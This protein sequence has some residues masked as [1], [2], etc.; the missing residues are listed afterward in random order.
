MSDPLTSNTPRDIKELFIDIPGNPTTIA[1][2]MSGGVDSSV[3][4]ALMAEQGKAQG[5]QVIGVTMKLWDAGKSGELND[6]TCCTLDSSMDARKVCDQLGIPHYTLDMTE[7]F[8]RLV[9]EPF[10]QAYLKAQTPNPCVNCNSFVKWDALWSKVKS[11]GVSHLA[12]GHYAETDH[13]D[14]RIYIYRGEDRSKDQSYFLW[15][16]PPENLQST[17]FPITGMTKPEVREIARQYELQT[18]NKSESMDICFIPDG[19]KNAFL[20]NRAKERG[21]KFEGGAIVS[22]D[23]KQLGKHKGLQ[24]FTIGQRKGLGVAT[25]EPVYVKKLDR[26]SNTLI[27]GRKE[28]LM[29]SE[30]E[31]VELNWFPLDQSTEG[32]D[33]LVQVRYRSKALPGKIQFLGNHR[34][35]VVLAEPALSIT[36]GQSAVFYD[37][38]RVLGGGVITG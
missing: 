24:D 27:L 25:G 35:S 19:D 21:D 2:A 33:I 37:G 32:L 3:A 34:V 16:I 18:A 17:L 6:K 1:V 38:D 5:F 22:P 13:K 4:A 9:M 8:D 36:P 11:I 30:F 26:E 12:T 7:D 15:G 10:Y 14:E 20:K 23:G 28:S 29:S 31:V